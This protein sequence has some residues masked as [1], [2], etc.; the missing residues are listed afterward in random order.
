MAPLDPSATS[1]SNAYPLGVFSS[2]ALV[3]AGL[4]AYLVRTI[5]RAARSLP[6]PTSTRA[7]QPLRDRHA[8]L[9]AGLAFFSIAA[10]STFSAAWRILSYFDWAEQRNHE[11][12][13]SLWTGW[14]GTGEEGVGR[15][16][17]GDW[18]SDVDLIA[19]S[20]ALSV[21]STEGFLYTSQHA[22]G[23]AAAAIFFGVE[24]RR[25]NLSNKTIAA[26]VS[27]SLVGSLGYALNLFFVTILFTPVALHSEDTLKHNALF[28]PKPVFLYTPV[29]ASFVALLYL[30]TL[31]AGGAN[32]TAVRIGYYAIPFYLAFAPQIIPAS[33]GQQHAT[34]EAAHRSFA[35]TFWVLGLTSFGLC[36]DLFATIIA[37]NTPPEQTSVY[38]LFKNAMGKQDS[39]NRFLQGLGNAAQ[40]LKH[41]SKHPVISITGT[42]VFFTVTGLLAWTFVRNL[43]IDDI[44]DNSLLWYFSSSQK[45]KHVAFTKEVAEVADVV[46]KKVEEEL[47]PTTPKRRGRP[48]KGTSNG[49]GTPAPAA[50]SVRRS[51][52]RK[53]RSDFESDAE[54]AYEPPTNA[55]KEVKQTETDGASVEDLVAGGESTALTLLLTFLGGLGQL[56]AGVLGAEVIGS[57]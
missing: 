16:R 12:P 44:L 30:P 51:T 8:A 4:S 29:V 38:D 55:V 31:I 20:D 47:P 56:A 19:E 24:G 50:G 2:Q 22:V 36:W 23:L 40:Q 25:R 39:S 53:A 5:R 54:S 46:E 32:L 45:E 10:V 33:W 1:R 15:W 42:D 21:G 26:F 27:L 35:R 37:A 49:A 28:A 6:P 14:Y 13:G 11:A 41:V 3:V 34:K 48:K 43:E 52:R 18:F 9:F 17:L 7:Q 57:S